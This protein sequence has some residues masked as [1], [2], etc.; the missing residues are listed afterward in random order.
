MITFTFTIMAALVFSIASQQSISEGVALLVRLYMQLGY[1]VLT[2]REASKA[3]L[4]V[5][6]ASLN[7]IFIYYAS[8]LTTRMTAEPPKPNIR[9]ESSHTLDENESWSPTLKRLCLL[10]SS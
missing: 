6:A 8:D 4:L 9:S 3:L 2:P 1:H 5:S 7:I 10:S